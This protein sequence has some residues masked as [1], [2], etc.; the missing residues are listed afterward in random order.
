MSQFHGYAN[1][2]REGFVPEEE[3]P[4]HVEQFCMKSTDKDPISG[5]TCDLFVP[6]VVDRNASVNSDVWS[7]NAWN[8]IADTSNLVFAAKLVI[9]LAADALNHGVPDFIPDRKTSPHAYQEAI[10]NFQKDKMGLLS[11]SQQQSLKQLTKKTHT[12]SWKDRKS[13]L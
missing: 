3:N 12:L 1:N 5:F 8:S 10:I 9:S 2:A 6:I 7:S 13:T 11:F 4:E